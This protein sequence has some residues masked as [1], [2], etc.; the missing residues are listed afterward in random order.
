MMLDIDTIFL[1]DDIGY[2]S[3]SPDVDFSMPVHEDLHWAS[4]QK[5]LFSAANL[6]HWNTTILDPH[7]GALFGPIP[8]TPVGTGSANKDRRI[9]RLASGYI[10]LITLLIIA[11]IVA[12]LIAAW[13]IH[14]RSEIKEAAKP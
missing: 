5:Y 14:K 10:A 4:S 12:I 11:A 2:H 7:L 3:A 9:G 6:G 1:I 13:F 8:T